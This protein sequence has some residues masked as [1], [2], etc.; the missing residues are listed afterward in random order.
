[1]KVTI[2]TVSGDSALFNLSKDALESLEG[3]IIRGMPQ[4]LRSADKKT[5]L[6]STHITAFTIE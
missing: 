6:V 1:M 2:K 5:A 3:N 4:V